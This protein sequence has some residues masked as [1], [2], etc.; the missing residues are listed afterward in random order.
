MIKESDVKRGIGKIVCNE[1]GNNF[2]ILNA[3]RLYSASGNR[4]FILVLLDLENKIVYF[5]P[6]TYLLTNCMFKYGTS[7]GS[8]YI[9]DDYETT[10]DLL[11]LNILPSIIIY[12]REYTSSL[13][14][15]L[16]RTRS[17]VFNKIPKYKIVMKDLLRAHAD[18]TSH[19]L[20]QY[21]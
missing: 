15:I 2:C 17:I 3:I 6:I 10:E 9:E 7:K 5:S 8:L 12:V 16:Y 21:E 4:L 11:G 19:L 18:P 1:R 14:R 20:V 13:M